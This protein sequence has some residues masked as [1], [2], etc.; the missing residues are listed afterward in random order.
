M[1]SDR[2]P[3]WQPFSESAADLPLSEE[4]GLPPVERSPFREPAAPQ[5][6]VP[7]QATRERGPVGA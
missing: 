6:V 1:T 2:R 5:V 4:R 3:L 7:Q